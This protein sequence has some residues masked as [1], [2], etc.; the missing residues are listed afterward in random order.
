MKSAACL[1]L[2]LSK[3]PRAN[4]LLQVVL[5]SAQNMNRAKLLSLQ[6]TGKT[7]LGKAIAAE[8]NATFFSISASSLTSK[9]VSAALIFHRIPEERPVSGPLSLLQYC[10]GSS[11]FAKG[12]MVC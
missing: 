1:L 5:V 3:G 11:T 10:G 6:G 12:M 8:A 2:W 4:A 9:W 7:L